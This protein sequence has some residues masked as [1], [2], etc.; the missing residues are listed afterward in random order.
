METIVFCRT[1]DCSTS[2]TW[3]MAIHAGGFGIDIR[4]SEKNICVVKCDSG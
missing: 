3:N 1:L 4:D 2:S